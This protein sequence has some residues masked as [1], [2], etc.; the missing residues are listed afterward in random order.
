MKKKLKNLFFHSA[1]AVIL[2]HSVNVLVNFIATIKELLPLKSGNYYDWR[3]GKLYYEK[4][5]SGNPLLL[6]HELNAGGSGQEWNAVVKELS[7]DH[8]V[9]TIDLLGC[10]RSEKPKLTYTNF[11]YVQLLSDFIKNVI[12]HKTD[13]MVSGSSSQLVL[14]ACHYSDAL[15][16]RIV[17]VNPDNLKQLNKI[18]SKKTKTLKFLLEIPIIGTTIYHIL[19]GKYNF[20]H[21]FMEHYFYNPF[22]VEDTYIHSYYEAAH[23]DHSA[24]KYLYAS[25]IGGY[26][27]ANILPALKAI[28]QSIYIIGGDKESNISDTIQGYQEWNPSIEATTIE[29]SKHFPH[30]EMPG[31]FLDA[32]SLYL[33]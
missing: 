7:K 32:I 27:N 13:V 5:G 26:L 21:E 19:T 29:K 3:F 30:M 15:F 9:Y 22:K 33:S 11:L 31:A 28:N 1:L 4:Q 20:D 23:L 6:V 25:L 10:G 14:M 8:T 12:G 24:G 18:P 17:L 2:L 16:N